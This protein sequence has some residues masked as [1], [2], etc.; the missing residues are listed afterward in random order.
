MRAA[1]AGRLS[2]IDELLRC[3]AD[4]SR[5]NMDGNN[6]LWLACV[7][8]STDVVRAL[9]DAGIDIDNR[10][11]MGATCLMYTASA[12]KAGMVAL[13]LQCGADPQILNFDDAR[14]VDLAATRPCLQLLRHTI[15]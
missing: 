7:S 9:V 8:G 12:G 13:L 1:L 3:G 15:G 5:R 14:A 2:L 11:D 6:A 10:N 4:I